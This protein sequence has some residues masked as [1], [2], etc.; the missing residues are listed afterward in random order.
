MKKS[1]DLNPSL[2]DRASRIR[3]AAECAPDDHSQSLARADIG[4]AGVSFA[5]SLEQLAA[6]L[7]EA[8]GRS[9]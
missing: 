1:Q 9:E 3:A 6:A 8:E 7:A 2:E 5:R 4:R